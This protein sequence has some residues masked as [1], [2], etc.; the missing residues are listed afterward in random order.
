MLPW[1][2]K[3]KPKN[4]VD[5][6]GQENIFI[7]IKK[8][9]KNPILLYGPTGTGKT[10][11]V[12]AL[13]RDLNY[14]IIEI[15][16][17]QERNKE[18]V[19][20]IIGNAIK[21]QSLFFKGKIILI[22]DI[23]A[24]SGTKDRGCLQTLIPL[25]EESKHPI[26]MTCT[27][28]F[29]DKLSCLRKKTSLIEFQRVSTKEITKKLKEICVLE[30]INYSDADVKLIAEKSQGDFRAAINDL[31]TNLFEDKIVIVEDMERDKTK[32]IIHCLKKVLK[33]KN[34]E[35]SINIFDKTDLDID[36]IFLWI[37]EN[38][39]K[40]YDP[41][42]LKNAYY[43]L[44]RG[45]VFKGRIRRQQYWRLLVY[46]NLLLTSGIAVS[47]KKN[48]FLTF[49]KYTRTTRILKLWQAKIRNSK[50]QVICE[51]LASFIH[52]SKKRTMNSFPEIRTILQNP[53]IF[54]L[55]GLSEDEVSWLKR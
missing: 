50:K 7:Q 51:K 1:T 29:I 13:A 22:D 12:Y 35:E 4:I 26:I 38:L 53:D 45:D 6:I 55:L 27:D 28:P 16:S 9:L 34:L 24:I 31:Q 14:E 3:Y 49:T 21:Q 5:V 18:S 23:D 39:P 2:E 30:K 40:E 43:Y 46:I 17:S 36:E 11:S 20:N 19:T 10:S 32:D 52:L 15:N 8:N 41:E 47:K 25:I 44:S 33:D 37:D 42:E 54:P 48:K